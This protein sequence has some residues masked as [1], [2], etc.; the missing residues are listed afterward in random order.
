MKEYILGGSGIALVLLMVML[1]CQTAKPALVAPAE[2]AIQVEKSG[3]SPTGVAGQNS[4]EL[5]LLY[6]NGDVIKTWKVEL[7]SAGTAQKTW[8]GD[9]KY[10]PASLTWDGKND[11]GAMAPEGTYTAKLSIDYASKYQ[12][13][14]EESKSFVLDITPPTGT[15]A[16]DP[17]QFTPSENGVQSPMTLTIN[18]SSALAHMD[19]WSLDVLDP[20]GGLVKNW[21]GQWSNTT[22]NWDGSSMNGGFVTPA[23]TYQAT[24]TVRDEYGNSSQLKANI[25][26]AALPKKAPVVAQAPP[27]P[28][29]LAI[30]AQSP[31]FSPNGDKTNDTITFLMG[32]GQPT[33]VVSW[34]VSIAASG[35]GTQK[36]YSGDGA[37][38]P[39]SID[40]DGKSDSGAMSPEGTYMASLAVDYGAA[41]SAGKAI[42]QSFVLDVSPPTGTISLSSALFSPIESANTISLKLTAS[43]K[44]A[45]I[46]SWT[47]DIYD[48]GGNVFTSFTKKWPSDTAVWD[49]KGINGDMVQSA[50]DYPVVAKVRDQFGNIGTVKATVPI[51][52]LVEKI[53]TGYRILASRIF[54]K[55]FTAD[56]KDVPPELA[57]Q[58][59]ARLDALAAKLKKFPDYK[60]RMIGHAVMINWDKPEA[61]REEQQAILIPLSKARAEAVKAALVDRGLDAGRF[62]TEGVGASDQLVPDSNYKDRWQNRRV[63]LFL[64]KE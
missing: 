34:K 43:S 60:I 59:M 52:I 7:T 29:Q 50:E 30:L 8:T 26:V 42:S 13:V 31:G 37:N 9:S 14:S 35:I 1:G 11:T 46:D 12:S 61:G 62:T 58:N 48:P 25:S 44:L 19:S 51:D 16:M 36:T 55:A 63:A 45:K 4:I 38:L 54:F 28:G 47:M 32:Y 64:D 2:S 56:Y 40:W 20:A 57:Q 15:I 39:A 10:L 53:A 49:G 33:A 24:A 18:A 22:A 23:T 3:F 17:A 41:F 21:S 6:G 5:S 27:K